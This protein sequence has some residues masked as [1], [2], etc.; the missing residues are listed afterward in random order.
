MQVTTAVVPEIRHFWFRRASYQPETSAEST[1]MFESWEALETAAL[2]D[3]GVRYVPHTLGCHR[4][5][6]PAERHV[7][8]AHALVI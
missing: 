8:F 3:E 7:D 5:A 4:L 1:M 6:G 2:G